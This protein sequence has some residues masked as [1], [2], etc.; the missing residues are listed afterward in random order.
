M[1]SNKEIRVIDVMIGTGIIPSAGL[2]QVSERHLSEYIEIYNECY[3]KQNV[4]VK[5]VTNYRF[6]RKLAGLTLLKLN[7]QRGA[8]VKDVDAGMVYLIENP[9]FVSH[10]KVG[11]TL[12]VHERLAQYQTY[13]P[14]RSFKIVKYEFVLNRRLKEKELLLHPDVVNETG[15]W[16][17]KENAIKLFEKICYVPE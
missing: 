13:D 5:S 17:A 12:D 9:V 16:I 6:A 11:M 14:H 10:Y 1:F 2:F 7:K 3:G 8:T 15:E 4:G